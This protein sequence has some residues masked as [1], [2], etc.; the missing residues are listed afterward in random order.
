MI[1]VHEA[2]IALLEASGV[3]FEVHEHPP[4]V[5][6][7]EA[8]LRAPNLVEDL[9]KTIVFRVKDAVWV[10]A[11]VR[12]HDRI[13]YR[14]LAEALGV[15]RKQIRSL[16][17]Q[18][19]EEQLGFEVGGVGPIPIRGDVRVIFDARLKETGRVRFGSGRNTRTIEMRFSDLLKVSRGALFPIA[20][21]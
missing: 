10:L 11:A 16:S 7:E 13:D 8:G 4:V 17:P 9:L 3:P 5:S 15:N 14:R 18:E 12:C 2:I 1:M 6:I 20:R 21:V 19:V